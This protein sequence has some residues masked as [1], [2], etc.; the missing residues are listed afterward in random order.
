MDQL[1]PKPIRPV[2]LIILIGGVIGL[3][4][5][6]L[7]Q[8]FRISNR[9]SKSMNRKNLSVWLDK[10]IKIAWAVLFLTL[11]VTSFLFFPSGLG[12]ATLVRPFGGL[13]LI[14]LLVL[15]TVPYLI[16]RLCRAPFCHCWLFWL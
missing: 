6:I 3:L 1:S 5:W 2:G 9:F 4:A 15:V 12:G 7:W 16:N 8:I 11:P 14:I 13:P 10:A